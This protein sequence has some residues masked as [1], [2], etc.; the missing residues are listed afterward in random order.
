MN[1]TSQT[2][3]TQHK[4]NS[5]IQTNKKHKRIAHT[6]KP[7]KQNTKHKAQNNI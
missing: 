2:Q 4:Q 7:H 1:K 5:H 3:T 6:Q